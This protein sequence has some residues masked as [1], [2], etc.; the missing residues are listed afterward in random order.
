MLPFNYSRVVDEHE[1]I[2][3]ASEHN[4]AIIAGGTTLVDLMKLDVMSP[5]SVVDISHLP[6]DSIEPLDDGGIKVGAL[7]RNSEL[8]HHPEVAAAFPVLSQAVASGASPQLR[9]MATVGGNLMQRT[10]CYYFRDISYQACNKRTPGS[11][12]AALEGYSRIHAILGTSDHCIATHPSDMAVA[13]LALDAVVHVKGL[14]NTRLIPMADF[15]LAPENTPHI[16]TVLEA[17]ELITHVTVPRS[18]F[19]ALSCYVKLRDRA[20]FEFALASAAV[21]LEVT[22]GQIAS[23]RV[24][25]GGVATKPWRSHEA[26]QVLVGASLNPKTFRAAA[27][28]ALQDARPR[29]HNAFKIELAKKAIVSALVR[30]AKSVNPNYE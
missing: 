23:A 15:H 1:A 26:E 11:G 8:V 16:E 20:S 13:L 5:S 10:R 3:K 18:P 19:S 25:L 30:L 28:A 14:M 22:G 9:N 12:C 6:L 24:A 4:T 27:E 29:R 21:G 2:Q 17:D 7:V